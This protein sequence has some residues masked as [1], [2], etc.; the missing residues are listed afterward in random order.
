M[1]TRPPYFGAASR[2]EIP[3]ELASEFALL[4]YLRMSPGE[5]K[6]IWWYRRRMYQNF[7]IAKGKGKARIIS[8]PDRR[9]KFVQRRIA[10]LFDA[11]YKRR[12]PV[13]GFVSDRS[14]KTNALSHI[15]SKF[16]LN[17]DLE[18]FFPS[19]TESRVRG[20]LGALGVEGRVAA[21]LARIC[22]NNG[23]LPQGAPSG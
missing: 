15:K 13:H 6:K 4:A 7:A 17:F 8:A 2:G 9:L 21:V 5:L 1:P 11:I 23:H 19:I 10:E 12:N 16:V 20:V 18:N 22:C 3:P 14:V